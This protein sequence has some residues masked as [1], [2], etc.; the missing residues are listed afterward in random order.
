MKNKKRAKILAKLPYSSDNARILA[1]LSYFVAFMV[2]VS[3]FGF[4]MTQNVYFFII[5]VIVILVI[6]FNLSRMGKLS[7][8]KDGVT[9]ER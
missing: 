3:F 2:V 8:G 9:L 5:I 6:L 4:L 1:F 7:F